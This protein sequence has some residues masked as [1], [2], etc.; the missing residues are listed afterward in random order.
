MA[1]AFPQ[2]LHPLMQPL[3]RLLHLLP[4]GLRDTQQQVRVLLQHVGENAGVDVQGGVDEPRRVGSLE[5][6]REKVSE[7]ATESTEPQQVRGTYRTRGV[8][9]VLDLGEERPGDHPGFRQFL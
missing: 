9:D 3:Q 1:E 4:P 2:R 8:E 5:G 6:G 7:S